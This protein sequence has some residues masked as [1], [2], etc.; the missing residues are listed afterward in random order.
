MPIAYEV[1]AESWATCSLVYAGPR[2]WSG[3]KGLSLQLHTLREGEPVVV[4][5]YQGKTPEELGTFAYRTQAA[6]EAADGWQG[7][8]IAWKEFVQPSW[9]GDGKAKFDPRSAMGVAVLFEGEESGTRKGELWL[10]SISLV[11]R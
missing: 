1:A 9:Q 3:S 6:K 7:L 8:E 10:D 5:V 2:D 11:P 4:V